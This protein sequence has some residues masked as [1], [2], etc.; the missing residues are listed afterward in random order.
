MKYLHIATKGN[1]KYRLKKVWDVLRSEWRQKIENYT[2][3]KQ[4]QWRGIVYLSQ[5]YKPKYWKTRGIKE[6][7][8]P[9][10]LNQLRSFLPPVNKRDK[11]IRLS[12]IG[13]VNC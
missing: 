1:K 9:N 11:L 5:E 8:T 2:F 6:R 7:L 10:N 12:S 13:F 4:I 3:P